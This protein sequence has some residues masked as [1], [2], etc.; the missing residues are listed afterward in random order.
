MSSSD[1]QRAV[2]DKVT[3]CAV[4]F[5]LALRVIGDLTAV[6]QVASKSKENDTLDLGLKG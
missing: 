6:L 2:T 4:D 1:Y 3:D 5:G